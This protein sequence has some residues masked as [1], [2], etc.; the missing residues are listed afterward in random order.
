[1]ESIPDETTLD[2]PDIRNTQE[3]W[4]EMIRAAKSSILL[5]EFYVS[6]KQGESLEPV[7]RALEN[8]AARGVR[9]RIIADKKF[10]STYP[11]TLDRWMALPNMVCRTIDFSTVAK[12]GVQ[13]AK[14]FIIDGEQVFLGSQ[15]FDWR[16]LSH[17][18]EIGMRIAHSAIAKDLQHLFEMDWD[19]A[20]TGDRRSARIAA[21]PMT[22]TFPVEAHVFTGPHTPG[23]SGR[24]EI[25][26]IVPVFSPRG[27]LPDSTRW[28]GA[29][30][31]DM[32]DG[33][34]HTVSVHVMSYSAAGDFELDAALRRAD[35]RGVRIRLLV[36][37]WSLGQSRLP[38]L[39]V[40][41]A[42]PNTEVRFTVIPQHSSGFIP[43]ARVEHC[44]Y[45]VVDDEHAW[46]G[47]NNW[48]KDYF[49]QSRNV[50][51]AVTGH[52]CAHTLQ[53]V[54]E[55]SWNSSYAEYLDPGKEYSAPR[56][57]SGDGR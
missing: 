11:K 12:G 45:L 4:I 7:V 56:T 49:F 40:L 8:A 15:N 29:L 13:H 30:L 31:R 53:N 17:I 16:S 26:K 21:G 5:E 2:N 23:N 50:G 44:K 28:D 14:F 54:F 34:V 27:F 19:F 24:A 41:Q 42:L 47:T 55:K 43:F 46:V 22:G 1:M 25:Q 3:V 35:A 9:V 39:R 10:Y 32:I 51:I 33:A 52:A 36:A 57:S 37:N 38:A 48:S 20:E 18:H 6:D